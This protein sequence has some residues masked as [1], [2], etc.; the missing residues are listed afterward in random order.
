MFKLLG[1]IPRGKFT[2]ACSG[3]KDSMTFF[4]F[5]RKFKNDMDLAYFNHGTVHGEEA[6][7]FLKEQSI[8]FSIPLRI[9]KITRDKKKEE[10]PEEYWRNERYSFLES[11]DNPVITGQHLYD[12]I[13]TWIFSSMRGRSKLI[14]YKRNNV[15]RPF[16]MVNKKE[17]ENW[18]ERNPIDW[19][20]D[21]SNQDV[22][23][24]RNLI[25]HQMMNVAFQINPGLETMIRKKLINEWN[26]K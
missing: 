25:R 26:D 6:E 2:L 9:G 17:L 15:L 3:G 21:P 23:Y 18:R 19:I 1:R 14:P 22:H 24:T 4:S 8:K 11:I 7:R 13:E 10:S 5:L 12:V 20:E 16:L